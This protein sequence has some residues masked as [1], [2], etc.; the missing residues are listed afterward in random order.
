MCRNRLFITT[1]VFSNIWKYKTNNGPTKYRPFCVT[2]HHTTLKPYSTA[3]LSFL[4]SFTNC[5]RETVYLITPIWRS[6][7]WFYKNL[8]L[9]WSKI[10]L[11]MNHMGSHHPLRHLKV[12]VWLISNNKGK[13]Q[14]YLRNLKSSSQMSST[15][16]Q[17]RS[18]VTNRPGISKVAGV[19]WDKLIVFGA[20]KLITN[21]LVNLFKSKLEHRILNCF[22]PMISAFH[23][24]WN[25]VSVGKHH[26]RKRIRN[27]C[28]PTPQCK[29]VLDIKQALTYLE[30]DPLNNQL[31]LKLLTLKLAMLLALAKRL[32]KIKIID[33]K[34]LAGSENKVVFSV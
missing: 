19:N 4:S 1:N 22:S 34:F 17:V 2:P 12:A 24:D 28:I 29:L 31:G 21:F 6:Q 14:E 32:P 5:K 20:V 25:S 13:Q 27:S 16:T 18:V 11:L 15:S 3:R 9:Q 33:T 30:K 26:L 7:P 8:I 23:D 10:S